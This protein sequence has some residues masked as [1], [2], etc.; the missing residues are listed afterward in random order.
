MNARQRR[1]APTREPK[2][3]TPTEADLALWDAA[4][5]CTR[6]GELFDRTLTARRDDNGEARFCDLRSLSR[7]GQFYREKLRAEAERL[8]VTV[9]ILRRECARFERSGEWR[10][11]LRENIA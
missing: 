6:D 5:R 3:F 7:A 8:G 4:R 2:P 10:R 1:K 11:W 9:E